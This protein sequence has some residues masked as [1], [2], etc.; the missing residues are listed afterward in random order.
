MDLKGL[1]YDVWKKK[2]SSID[3][4]NFGDSIQRYLKAI[5]EADKD[6]EFKFYRGYYQ[7]LEQALNNGDIIFAGSVLFALGRNDIKGSLANCYFLDIKE[8]SLES[9]F[10]TMNDMAITYA[11]RG[12][13]GTDISNLRP[14][15]SLTKNSAISST[16]SV[17]FMPLLSKVTETIGQNGRRGALLMTIRDTHPDVMDF[18]KSKT[19]LY[20]A[21]I[22]KANISVKISDSTMLAYREKKTISLYF[23]S[24]NEEIKKDLK[25]EE[26]IHEI[27]VNSWKNADPGV[28]FWDRVVNY[29]PSST[30]DELR[31][32]GFNP[33]GEQS[34]SDGGACALAHVNFANIVDNP[35][36]PDAM[37]NYG[38]LKKIIDL[39]IR[40][41][42]TIT[43]IN[44]PKHPLKKQKE[45]SKLG[46]ELGIG[47]TGLGD[48]FAQMNVIYGS[49]ESKTL[50]KILMKFFAEDCYESSYQLGCERGIAQIFKQYKKKI[51]KYLNCEYFK[52]IV[53]SPDLKERILRKKG[54]RNVKLM[55]VAP[56]GSTS[57]LLGTTSGIE[58]L[59]S[60]YHTRKVEMGGKPVLYPVVHEKIYDAMTIEEKTQL[61]D[62]LKNESEKEAEDYMKSV[63]KR[64][65]Y[66]EAH[67]IDW[68]DRIDIQSISQKYIDNSISSTINLPST[69]TVD[70]IEKIY[71]Y[72]WDKGLKGITVYREGSRTGILSKVDQKAKTFNISEKAEK[73]TTELY[74]Q[75]MKAGTE[76]I[77]KDLRL[78][79]KY[80]A[81]GYVRRVNNKKWY[82]HV[83]YADQEMKRPFALF[84]QSNNKE[85]VKSIEEII[86]KIEQ[87]AVDSKIDK[88][89]MDKHLEETHEQ[90]IVQR[91]ARA[92]SL[93]LRHNFQIE[94][95]CELLGT[96][97]IGTV[98]FQVKKLLSEYIVT[99]LNEACPECGAKLSMIEGC[100]MCP[101]C[102]MAKCG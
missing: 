43:E 55:S 73:Q 83:S 84:I 50:M 65:N 16:G 8:D 13:C 7:E 90:D 46:R 10:Q 56:T 102:G 34:L 74:D 51:N 11:H 60:A 96:P 22:E 54:I 42:D 57:L 12:G 72:A 81:K 89:I 85:P 4:D 71:V 101:S 15:G 39:V 61:E 33:C 92:V 99:D 23:K 98:L 19:E 27:A 1:A 59:F 88:K 3:E 32:M 94:K 77:T 82:F 100:K 49:A 93:L 79:D 14:K 26:L 87:F 91:F 2:Y 68:K 29:C 64:L 63:V 20:P 53:L 47:F 41:M 37:I 45:K 52:G 9:I 67:E 40:S 17:S 24:V 62:F 75:F 36:T 97:T 6:N 5:K 25:A 95:I 35:F 78:P 18:I 80:I 70:D 31:P 38:K 58:P 44:L 21:D 48:L 69:A 66:V 76:I 30:Y 86:G 28:A